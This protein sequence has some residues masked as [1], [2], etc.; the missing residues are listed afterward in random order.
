MSQQRYSGIGGRRENE[1]AD[2][3]ARL[4]RGLIAVDMVLVSL[5]LRE[6]LKFINT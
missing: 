5:A 2:S 6:T 3:I 4:L 1:S